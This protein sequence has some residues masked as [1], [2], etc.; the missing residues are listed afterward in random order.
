MTPL[1]PITRDRLIRLLTTEIEAC[2]MQWEGNPSA[3][4]LAIVALNCIETAPALLELLN[5]LAKQ[6]IKS[7]NLIA[8]AQATLPDDLEPHWLEPITRSPLVTYGPPSY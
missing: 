2:Q 1:D 5:H 3:T 8:I 4:I 7:N 6:A